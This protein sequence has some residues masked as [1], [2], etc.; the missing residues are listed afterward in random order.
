MEAYQGV[1]VRGSTR[2]VRK[3]VEHG[4]AL[5]H[6]PPLSELIN[7]GKGLR[8]ETRWSPVMVIRG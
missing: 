4:N 1:V 2:H 8:H 7:F 3:W 5:K 6:M